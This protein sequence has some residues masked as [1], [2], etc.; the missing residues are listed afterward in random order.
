MAG[1]PGVV[2]LHP[3]DRT[4]VR[5]TRSV[6]SESKRI[7]VVDDDRDAAR[8]LA[9]V[10]K[11]M[12]HQARA[13]TDPRE[14]IRTAKQFH[15]HLAILDLAMPHVSG[16]ELAKMFRGDVDLKQVCLVALSGFDDAAHRQLTREA[17][18]DAHVAKPAD[19]HILRSILAQFDQP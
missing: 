18:F 12:G 7:L 14:A 2:G 17:G 10:F 9:D 16:Y 1:A 5:Y 4:T 15:P 19:H 3:V 6:A 8:S 13:V 11:I